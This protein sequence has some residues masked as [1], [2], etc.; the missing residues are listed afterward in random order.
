[1]TKEKFNS[2]LEKLVERC[3]GSIELDG[4]RTI[5]TFNNNTVVV[6]VSCGNDENNMMLINC[7]KIEYSTYNDEILMYRDDVYIG[8]GNIRV[9]KEMHL[10]A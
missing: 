4:H 5:F 7:T 9:I 10:E 1:M 8:I 2:E 6:F 3:G